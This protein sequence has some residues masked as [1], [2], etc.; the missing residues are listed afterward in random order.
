VLEPPA[1]LDSSQ[2]LMYAIVDTSVT[3]TGRGFVIVGDKIIDPV[4]CLAIIRNLSDDSILLCHCDDDWN[5]LGV[6]GYA[7]P[8]EAQQSAEKAYRGVAAKW[9]PFRELTADELAAV[10]ETR[11]QLRILHKRSD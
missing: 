5:V 1:I 4:P 2:M 9:Q 10:K 8:N 3:Y 6:G 7:S 11:E